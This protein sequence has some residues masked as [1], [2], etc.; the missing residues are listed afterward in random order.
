[1]T[2]QTRLIFDMHAISAKRRLVTLVSA[3]GFCLL[4]AACA[5]SPT[6]GM[7]DTLR[8]RLAKQPDN[9]TTT[10]NLTVQPSVIAPSGDPLSGVWAVVPKTRNSTTIEA[11]RLLVAKR[12]IAEK[13]VTAYHDPLLIGTR[14]RLSI[15]D[16]PT[17]AEQ[18]LNALK[19]TLHIWRSQSIPLTTAHS[20][21]FSDADL[22]HN[23]VTN[24]RN[25]PKNYF[26]AVGPY[27]H[28]TQ[29]QHNALR[30][31]VSAGYLR[32]SR[33]YVH[34]V[35]GG[36]SFYINAGTD[37]FYV[38]HLR[39]AP[40]HSVRTPIFV[41]FVT[42]RGHDYLR[43][44]KN[45]PILNHFKVPAIDL[46]HISNSKPLLETNTTNLYGK[47]IRRVYFHAVLQPTPM[48]S[49]P[50]IRVLLSS[51]FLERQ[52]RYIRSGF[53]AS[54]AFGTP[55]LHY[56]PHSFRIGQYSSA[57][58]S[59]VILYR[60]TPT[61]KKYIDGDNLLVGSW[62]FGHITNYSRPN[63][64]INGVSGRLVDFTL[65]FH[66]VFTKSEL[67]KL[68]PILSA[69]VPAPGST[70]DSEC[71]LSPMR[72]GWKLIRCQGWM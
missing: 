70:R 22:V 27:T 26:F 14:W 4:I 62:D 7:A 6:S 46:L 55:G 47:K 37:G 8:A 71:L 36:A 35:Y 56:K 31:L 17:L 59:S 3:V 52:T 12:L 34:A 25:V 51:A 49:L 58:L 33:E 63:Q 20:F 24:P 42:N 32:E 18:A 66:P 41:Y 28:V 10:L 44:E 39:G 60:L 48:S 30:A 72:H 68:R 38:L 29:K 45:E 67:E 65:K 54:V 57:K 23:H 64:T 15:N 19:S 50:E 61:G 53:I 69:S 5:K 16:N 2:I 43:R 13:A 40:K 1:M 11:F 9:Q 21:Y